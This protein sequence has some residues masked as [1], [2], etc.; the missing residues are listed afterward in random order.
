MKRICAFSMSFFLLIIG[1]ALGQNQVYIIQYGSNNIISGAKLNSVGEIT[2][3]VYDPAKQTTISGLNNLDISQIGNNNKIG[4][5]QNGFNDN[6]VHIQQ[7]GIN[8][9][10]I[11]DNAQ[12]AGNNEANLIDI[13]QNGL[14]NQSKITRMSDGNTTI[15]NQLGDNNSFESTVYGNGNLSVVNQ[16][17]NNNLVSQQLQGDEMSYLFTQQGNGN[18]LIQIEK[19]T[20]V[21]QYEVYQRG[22]AMSITIIN[23][24]ILR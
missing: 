24:G 12:Y 16:T 11:F 18:Q 6:I 21:M 14:Y 3:A 4:V 17:G 15:L 23:G 1:T 9:A 7:V 5:F 2:L 8:E 13:V 10:I 19:N 22:N 20:P